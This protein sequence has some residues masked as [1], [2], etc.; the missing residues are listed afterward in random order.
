M[1]VCLGP[2]LARLSCSVHIHV[3]AS[4]K[5]VSGATH[6]LLEAVSLIG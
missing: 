2:S 4:Q 6:L 5:T 3:N 1:T